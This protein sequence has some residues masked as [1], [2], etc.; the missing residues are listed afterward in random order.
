[1]SEEPEKGQEVP[2]GRAN[3]DKSFSIYQPFTEVVYEKTQEAHLICEKPIGEKIHKKW[4][5]ELPFAYLNSFCPILWLS[6]YKHYMNKWEALL[7]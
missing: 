2:A 5:S 3:R 4:D 6:G 7:A 1:M